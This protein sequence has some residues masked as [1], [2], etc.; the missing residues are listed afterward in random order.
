VVLCKA[1]DP[2]AGT[3]TFYTNYRSPK[4]ADL[5]ANPRAAAVFH[6]DHMARQARFEG[7]VV[8]ISEAESDAYFATRPTLSQLGAWASEQSRPVSARW[9]IATRLAE[10]G[11]KFGLGTDWQR[12]PAG[13]QIP[14]PAHWGGFRIR[15]DRV[16]L[17]VGGEGRIHDRAAWSRGGA[18]SGAAETGT[19]TSVWLVERLQP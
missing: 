7:T 15:A 14:R 17:W 11:A 8:R 19:G 4:A 2:A 1:I 3:L 6:W 9:K 13:I 16:E 5:E 12:A 10:M 18:T